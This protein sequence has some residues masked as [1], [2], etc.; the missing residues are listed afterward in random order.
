VA[1][2]PEDHC[3]DDLVEDRPSPIHGRGVFAKRAIPAGTRI[4]TYTGTP[5]DENDTYVLW[6]E[7]DDGD[8]TG[9]DGTGVL[10]WLNHSRR[11]NVEFD[12]PELLAIRS[13][14]PDDELTFHYG[15]EW[16]HVD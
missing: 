1:S 11:P 10:R 4:G 12:G 13:I 5:T 3:L 6:V 15:Q 9:I 8:F 16:D 14:A 7:T 2:E